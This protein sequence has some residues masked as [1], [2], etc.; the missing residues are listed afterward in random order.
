MDID[1]DVSSSFTQYSAA[2]TLIPM[3]MYVPMPCD[4]LYLYSFV[5]SVDTILVI[6]MTKI[7]TFERY[8]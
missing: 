3:Y 1:M 6:K 4:Q 7:N 5:S 8:I 2:I